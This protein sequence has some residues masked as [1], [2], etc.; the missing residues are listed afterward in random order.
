MEIICTPNFIDLITNATLIIDTCVIVDTTK[1]AD[2][3]SFVRNLKDNYNTSLISVPAVKQEVLGVADDKKEYE[4]LE[5]SIEALNVLFLPSAV[6][7]KLDR[8]GMEF[9][10]AMRRSKETN[11]PS[12]VDRLLFSIPYLYRKSVEKIFVFTTNHKDMPLDIFDRVGF[13]SRDNG[14]EF[15]QVGLYQ[16]N[17]DKFRKIT[18]RA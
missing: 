13:I 14:K 9:S 6:E 16:F 4:T 2:F 18:Q 15:S 3:F 8:E 17:Q 5:K 11:K 10:I 1:S 12:F 7:D